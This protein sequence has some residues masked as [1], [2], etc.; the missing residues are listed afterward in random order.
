MKEYAAKFYKSKAWQACRNAYVH[1]ARGLCEPCLMAGRVT[2]G[3]IVHHKIHLT[4]D[5]IHQPEVTMDFSNLELVCRECHAKEHDQN[6][7]A[8]RF[9]VD[10][11]GRVSPL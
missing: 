11:L 10:E 9:T 2:P 8:R 1:Q 5:N 7:A 4:P 6:R 3:E